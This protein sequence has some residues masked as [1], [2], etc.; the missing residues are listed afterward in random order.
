M[1]VVVCENME[2]D[3]TKQLIKS[4][5]SIKSKIKQIKNEECENGMKYEKFFKPVTSPLKQFLEMNSLKECNINNEHS[6]DLVSESDISTSTP[7]DSFYD[8]E[9]AK[10]NEDHKVIKSP[11]ITETSAEMSLRKDDYDEIF[12]VMN[13]PYGIRSENKKLFIGNSSVNL[14]T[15]T[16]ASGKTYLMNVENRSYELTPGLKELLLRKKPNTNI[17]TDK[18][19]D[20]Y[21]DILQLTNVHKR[22]YNAAGQI[23]G[24]KGVKYREII[25]PLVSDI[26]RH[27]HINTE[28]ESACQSKFG[29]SLPQLKNYKT[30]TDLVYWDDPNELVE[31]LKLLIASKNAG[32]NN[33]NNEILSILEELQ[34][35]GIVKE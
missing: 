2:H 8:A 26:L 27:K 1:L 15:I 28:T 6:D 17:V 32:N 25:K 20:I 4:V 5:Q 24:D 9:I 11:N 31:R 3:I 14:K 33:H 19:K 7:F 34:E 35:A 10:D 22:D 21:K 30:C 13:V 16:K 12:D 29:G 18:D 23:R